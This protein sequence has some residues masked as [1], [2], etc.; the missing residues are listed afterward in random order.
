MPMGRPRKHDKDLPPRMRKKGNSYYY[1]G[2]WT[3]LGNDLAAA[4]IKWAELEGIS[5]RQTFEDA[6]DRY[7]ASDKF[8]NLSDGSKVVYKSRANQLRKIFGK[9]SCKSILPEHIYQYMDRNPS[10]IGA[11][12]GLVLIQHALEEARKRGWV[13]INHAKGI[14]KH[15]TKRRKRYITDEE[16]RAIYN[17]GTDLVKAVMKL[18][19][20]IGQRPVDIFKLRLSDITDEGIFIQQKKTEK[21]QLFL[22]TPELREAVEQAKKLPR[23]IR[24][25]TLF[26]KT[27]GRPYDTREFR[28]QWAAACKL[29]GVENAQF[30]DI[31]AKAGTDAY[32]AGQDHQAILGHTTKA[33]SDRYVKQ[34]KVDRVEPLRKKI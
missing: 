33:M 1:V 31:R 21:K 29:A 7:L 28:Y 34:F 19:Y 13:S 8:A 26:C 10:K 14:E 20:L 23:P 11:N 32:N 9:R 16:Y 15:A 12:Q 17:A 25:M 4:K 3:P 24:G 30:R 6:L 18:N 5:T 27:T 2:D 22:W